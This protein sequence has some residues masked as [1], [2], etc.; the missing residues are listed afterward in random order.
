MGQAATIQIRQRGTVTLPIKLREKYGL[1]DG[2]PVTIVD[3]DGVFL[4]TPRVLSVPGLAKELERLR[5]KRGLS[6]KDLG[7]PSREG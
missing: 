1:R 7:G 5:R 2:D 6:L 3:L 4:L